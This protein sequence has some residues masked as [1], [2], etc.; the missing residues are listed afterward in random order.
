MGRVKK[1]LGGAAVASLMS[2][3]IFFQVLAAGEAAAQGAGEDKILL[4]DPVALRDYEMEILVISPEEGTKVPEGFV[5]CSLVIDGQ[6]VPG[7]VWND[8][9]L[10]EYCI[11]Y[12]MNENG[13]SSYYRYDLTENTLQRYFHDPAGANEYREKYIATAMEYN[14]LLHDYEIRF[15]II[16]VLT[17]VIVIL[18]IHEV[19]QNS[20]RNR[21]TAANGTE[22]E[23]GSP[24]LGEQAFDAGASN[25]LITDRPEQ[26]ADGSEACSPQDGEAT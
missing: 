16:I 1:I 23:A 2:L 9:Q 4:T 6:D 12:G 26:S 5:P 15:W 11:F 14:A 19:R 24:D 10:P 8:D 18:L 25:Q 20:T 13:E 3:A 17:A 7:W 22:P 21:D